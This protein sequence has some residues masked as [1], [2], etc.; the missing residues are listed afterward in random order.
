MSETEHIRIVDVVDMP[1]YQSIE[2]KIEVRGK[3]KPGGMLRE[4]EAEYV[5]A[6]SASSAINP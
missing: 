1:V 4:E 5:A 6:S 3:G 2:R